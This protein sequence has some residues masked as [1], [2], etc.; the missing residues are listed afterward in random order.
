MQSVITSMEEELLAVNDG[1]KLDKPKIRCHRCRRF[2]NFAVEC[3]SGQSNYQ[4]KKRYPPQHG[5]KTNRKTP[6]PCNYCHIKG[7][8]VAD[9]RKKKRE[10][11]TIGL[12]RKRGRKRARAD[13]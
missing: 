7:H 5:G 12:K 9:C 11:E 10:R 1:K 13:T 8:R 4:H 6:Y 2:G 3:Q